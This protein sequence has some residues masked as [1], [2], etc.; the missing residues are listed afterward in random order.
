VD[1]ELNDL[2]R[3]VRDLAGGWDF[4]PQCDAW[5]RAHDPAF[6]RE[7]AR[8]GLIGITWPAGLGGGGR[9]NMARLVVTEE[10]LRVG[11]PVAAHWIA[12][13][14]IGPAILR[15][16]SAGLQEEF[17]PGIA[18]GRIT[19]CL[20][21]SETEAGSDLAS[22][23]TRAVRDGDGWQITGRKIWTTYAHRATHAY[24][25]ARSG[26]GG[27]KHDGLTEFIVDM[28]APGVTVRPIHDLGGEH[29]FNEVLLD[30]VFVP[31]G[32]VIGAEGAGWKQV[33]EQLSFE[34]GGMER[35]L[36]TYPLLAGF[37]SLD[38]DPHGRA[39]VGA[40]LARLMSLRELACRV[41]ESMDAG[42]APAG[43]AAVLKYLG[44]T[45]ERDVVDVA[46]TVSEV[47]PAPGDGFAGLLAQ[48][49]LAVPGF[50]IRDGTDEMLLTVVSRQAP[51][52]V[53]DDVGR[54]A[55]EVLGTA[56]DDPWATAVD[57][58]WA[59]VGVADH[60]GGS[61]GTFADLAALVRAT[62]RHACPMPLA[63]VAVAR[64]LT[65]APAVAAVAADLI[66]ENGRVTATADVGWPPPQGAL[67]LIGDEVAAR[68]DPAAEDVTNR[69][70][71]DLAGRPRAR[72]SCQGVP[73]EVIDLPSG[74]DP[75]ARLAVLRVH[76]AL[77]AVEGACR[78][79]REHVT[80]RV[81]FGRPLSR[82]QAVAH[83][84]AEMECARVLLEVAA[85][86]ALRLE[87][88]RV[89]AAV[90]LLDPIATT[91]TRLAHQFHGAM[92]VTRES[93]LHRYTTLLWSL[94]DESGPAR[95]WERRLYDAAGADPEA[96]WTAVTTRPGD[97]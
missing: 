13:R 43:E 44:T 68:V 17:L 56:P 49:Q 66:V 16:G 96:R 31:A 42:R 93:P 65:E 5:M 83:G 11:A 6:S 30:E 60:D 36:S 63:E 1:E 50:S 54:M 14:Q 58:G 74:L 40:L 23:R 38:L 39:A 69:P 67:L 61:G 48:A 8:S 25:L 78:L 95:R 62:G 2:R 22:V 33:T 4:T 72:I 85:S 27:D 75:A 97:R 53:I 46:R 7:L 55:D 3:R 64:A 45:F 88:V 92:G 41:A 82:L 59:A 76:A 35:V 91:V 32:H 81:Q 19:F 90:A 52:P 87:P 29:H 37:A 70:W 26:S 10:L 15:N 9:T 20:G 79:T 24:V 77:G 86:A 51:E 34:R 47:V 73:A 18:A 94:R 28:S 57:L 12:D 71:H 21:M 84:L 80:T 89:A